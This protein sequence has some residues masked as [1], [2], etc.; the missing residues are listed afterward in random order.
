M[1]SNV[2]FKVEPIKEINNGKK[3][4]ISIHV[5]TKLGW[6]DNVNFVIEDGNRIYAYKLNY[7]K[8][9]DGKALFETEVGLSTKAIYRYYFSYFIDGMQHFCKKQKLVDNYIIR[10]EMFKMSVNFNVP[11]W[12]K[13]KIMYHIFVDRYNRGSEEELKIMP[14]RFIYN[15][16]EDDMI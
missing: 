6:I 2:S 9:E 1:G 11:D 12:A 13:G 3:Y 10:D 8:N 4:K 5:P 7:Q 16:W 15:S 14:R